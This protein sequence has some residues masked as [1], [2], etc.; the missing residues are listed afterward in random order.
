MGLVCIQNSS[1]LVYIVSQ[2]VSASC[3]LPFQHS[4]GKNQSVGGFHPPPPGKN[5]KFKKLSEVA[6]NFELVDYQAIDG[7]HMTSKPDS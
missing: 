5:K 2:K 3:C 7:L 1:L 4:R 6:L